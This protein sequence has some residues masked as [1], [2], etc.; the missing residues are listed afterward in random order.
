ME[1]TQES[2]L[3]NLVIKITTT[4]KVELDEPLLKLIKKACK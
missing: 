4:G 3:I 2:E 1:E